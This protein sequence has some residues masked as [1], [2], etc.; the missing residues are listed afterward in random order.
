MRGPRFPAPG[1]RTAGR[2][3]ALL[4]ALLAAALP[5]P[6]TGQDPP[7]PGPGGATA[8]SLAVPGWGQWAQGHRRGV[9][10][11]V[12]EAVLWGYWLDR[13]SD[14]AALRRGYRD[15]A[16]TSARLPSGARRDGTWSYYETLSHW[17]R[18]GA[19]D[20][21]PAAPGVQP[22][23]DR[24]TYNGSIWGLARALHLAGSDGL[25]GDPRYEAAL[26][27]YRERA[28]GD[29]F[30]WDWTGKEQSLRE[31]RELIDA[32]DR[33]FRQA[34]GAVGAV[35]AN[36]LLSG[37]D[38]FLSARIPGSAQA[39]VLPSAPAGPHALALTFSWRPP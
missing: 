27:W 30:L 16:W 26:A 7:R 15:L 38:A 14:G 6:A 35:L 17:G 3:A 39:R 23:E 4:G 21:D 29:G 13:R 37:A 2:A 5:V 36:H 20:R 28:Y 25:P 1:L 31:Y 24:A 8:R 11:A 18:S 10:Y 22:E 9:A 34:T 19:F 12:V 33:R 32:S